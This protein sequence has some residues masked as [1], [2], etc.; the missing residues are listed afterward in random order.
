MELPHIILRPIV[1]GASKSIHPCSTLSLNAYRVTKILQL[2][3]RCD[4]GVPSP[5]FTA[6]SITNFFFTVRKTG[7]NLRLVRTYKQPDCDV[8]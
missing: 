2:L 3:G 8:Q 1:G 5:L 6:L 7:S 4:G